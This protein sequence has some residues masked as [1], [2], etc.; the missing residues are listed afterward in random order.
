[1]ID[2]QRPVRSNRVDERA[3]GAIAIVAGLLALASGAEPTGS[4]A[5]DVMLVVGSVAAVV[6]ASASA[7]WWALAGAAGVAAVVALE[8]I[9]VV[10][11]AAGFV[12]GLVIG[13]RRDDRA[14]LR[15][16]VA[17]IALN[18]LI[19][20]ELGG[21]LGL[22]AIVGVSIGLA[23]FVIG[24]RARPAAVRRVGWIVAATVGGIAVLAVVAAGVSAMSV[25][26]D[27]TSATKAARRAVDALNT[28]DYEQAATLFDEASQAF[29]SVDE[30][31][32]GPLSRM[33]LLI[34]GIAQNMAAGTDLAAAAGRSTGEVA[35]ALG[36]VDVESLR[37]V[38]GAIDVEAVRAIEQPLSDVQDSLVELRSVID[39]VRSPWLVGKLQDELTELDADF[40]DKEPRLQNAIDAVRLAPQ[41]LGADGPRRYLVMFNSP[42]ELRGITGFMGNYADVT[43]DNGRID[44]TE[45]GRRRDLSRFVDENGATCRGC[46]QEFIDRY[47]PYSLAVGPNLDVL[48]YGWQNIT[49]PAHFPYTAAAASVLYPQSGH[50][51]IDGVIALDPYVLQALMKYTGPVEVSEFDV[52]VRP[53]DAAKFILEDQYLLGQAASNA[54][55]IDALDT[56]G[57]Q[58]IGSLLEGSLPVPSDLARDLGP[59]V[60]ENRL[61]VWTTDPAERDLFGRIGLLGALPEIGDDGGFGFTVVNGGNSKI[62]VFLERESDVRIETGADGQRMLVADVALTNSAPASGLPPY[63][64]GN[65]YGLPDGT[66]RMLVTMYGPSTLRSLL[67]DGEAVEYDVAP[68]AGWTGYSHTVDVGPGATVRFRVEFE[69]GAPIDEVDEPVIWEQP[70]ADRE[71]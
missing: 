70:L 42:A 53:K 57:E 14:E 11:G 39:E 48:R 15:A 20:S 41:L 56:M 32:G 17:A 35:T 40:E 52:T 60:A 68:E 33:S 16:V 30:G 34:P 58:V 2:T 8:P 45:F 44:V 67:V 1:M 3:A 31:L 10:I 69:L 36:Q 21:F 19:R 27:L 63:V 61:L 71:Q 22:S 13:A 64:L 43:I 18:V 49:M 4:T 55:R 46:P 12:G 62:D 26:S 38:G 6:W 5:I 66:S 65:S 7:P 51:P 50:A 37:V 25:R 29:E 47:G 59:L 54:I 23:L 24:L 28:G 9:L